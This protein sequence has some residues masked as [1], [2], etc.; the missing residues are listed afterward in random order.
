M[1][2]KFRG[3]AQELR[4]AALTDRPPFATFWDCPFTAAFWVCLIQT[5][6]TKAR[7][8]AQPDH[9]FAPTLGVEGDHP[10]SASP[11]W[12]SIDTRHPSP[13]GLAKHLSPHHPSQPWEFLQG[14]S[15]HKNKIL[16]R[17]NKILPKSVVGRSLS[18]PNHS[19]PLL[20][21]PSRT[22]NTCLYL[23][24]GCNNPN[25]YKSTVMVMGSK[26]AAFLSSTIAISEL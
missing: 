23:S 16:N 7:A 8:A 18:L 11:R 24:C 1:T 4:R 13:V 2:F 14:Q 6:P 12:V 15:G 22:T 9:S 25:R 26:Q 17:K 3:R 19:G 21:S 5:N 20:T 10:P